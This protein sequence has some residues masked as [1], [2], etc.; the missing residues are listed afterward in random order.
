MNI[1][2]LGNGFDVAHHLPTY[3]DDFLGFAQRV[4]Y[5]Y[6]WQGN[7]PEY[8]NMHID[9]WENNSNYLKEQL[10]KIFSQRK[11]KQILISPAQYKFVVKV[12]DNIDAF[13]K[14]LVDN[15]W[16]H[17][18][19]T[20]ST[21]STTREEKLISGENWIDFENEISFIIQ[22]L[23]SEFTSLDE[24]VF[25]DSLINQQD[26]KTN[27]GTVKNLEYFNNKK[28]LTFYRICRDHCKEIIQN[29]E[30]VVPLR[31]L[32]D[33]LYDDLEELILA[34]DFY[35]TEFVEKM[36]IE[37][38][39][40][41]KEVNPSYVITFNYTNTFNRLYSNILNHHI[42]I[43]HVHGE[44]TESEK[45]PKENNIVIGIKE[46]W[47]TLEDQSKRTNFAIF[48]K[49]I[50]RIR[51]QNSIDYA[52]WTKEVDSRYQKNKNDISFVHIFGHSLDITDK[53]ILE[54]ILK[55]DAT[56]LHIYAKDKASEGSLISNLIMLIGRESVIKKSNAGKIIFERSE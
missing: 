39:S 17:Y 3:Y 21:T 45:F 46:Y 52:E 10:K 13:N 22:H 7:L 33:C 25:I 26:H 31:N 51:K 20:I 29:E 28:L 35:L 42:A 36:H 54:P 18:F 23:D 37:R 49:F 1:L 40:F 55:L 50:Q 16:L 5:I 53:D 38:L 15:V 12:N 30:N 14:Y 48:K 41:I 19:L 6:T 34:F 56:Y 11:P 8:V 24:R 43:C 47:E 4:L 44:C 32:R 9:T 2:I 27:R